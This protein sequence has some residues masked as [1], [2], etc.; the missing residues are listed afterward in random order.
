[1]KKIVTTILSLALGTMFVY[2]Q[3]TVKFYNI[4]S[5][6]T[7]TT[8]NSLSHFVGGTETGGSSAL[9]PTSGNAAWGFYYALLTA[10]MSTFTYGT[11]SSTNPVATGWTW[12]GL[13][14]TNTIIAGSLNGPGGNNGTTVNSW[15]SAPTD[16]S[17]YSQGTEMQFLIVGWSS[18]LGTG[19]VGVS[20]ELAT[21]TWT[22][23]GLFGVSEMGWGYSG[24]GGTPTLSTPSLFS[25]TAGMPGGLTKGFVLYQVPEP[26]TLAMAGLGGLSLL[27]FRRRK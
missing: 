6:F 23:L 14:G 12:T 3:G 1:M 13:Q 19:W 9:E 10:P 7:V 27:L 18:N 2:S 24:G 8:N 17:A 15:P 11:A 22:T 16:G 25:V 20:N 26:T 4:N 21:S 5:S